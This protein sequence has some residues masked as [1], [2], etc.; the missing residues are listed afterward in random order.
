LPAELE[1]MRLM[2]GGSAA[3]VE[4]GWGA[5]IMLFALLIALPMIF[6]GKPKAVNVGWGLLVVGELLG[7]AYLLWGLY[8]LHRTLNL[9]QPSPAEALPEASKVSLTPDRDLLPPPPASIVEGTT[10]LMDRQP[11]SVSSKP[12][13]TT[14]ELN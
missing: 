6:F 1:V 8:R 5:T 11:L 3:Q 13:R 9:S 2:G 12:A 7:L 14:G 4:I 10:E